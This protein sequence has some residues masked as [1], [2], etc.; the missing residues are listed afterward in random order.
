M[1][2]IHLRIRHGRTV[3]LEVLHSKARERERA[4]FV[5]GRLLFNFNQVGWWAGWMRQIKARA[6]G[7]HLA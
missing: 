4:C 2:G 6:Q 1:F 7:A 5:L 3:M